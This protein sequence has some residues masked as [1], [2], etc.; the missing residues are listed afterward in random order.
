MLIHKSHKTDFLLGKL[1]WLL[2]PPNAREI[3]VYS[4]VSSEWLVVV[5]LAVVAVLSDE[6]I[7]CKLDLPIGDF[8]HPVNL[9]QGCARTM[10]AV[11][12]SAG[13]TI[14]IYLIKSL[15]SAEMSCE[16]PVDMVKRPLKIFLKRSFS[17]VT[18]LKGKVPHIREKSKTPQAQISDG[19]P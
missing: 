3:R 1:C 2:Y 7:D 6:A 12:R 15:S 13:S 19:P 5:S 9:N 4:P 10:V 18:L 16:L 14:S 17:V 11:G 8:T